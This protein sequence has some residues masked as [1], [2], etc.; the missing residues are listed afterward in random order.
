MQEVEQDLSPKVTN[1]SEQHSDL[2]VLKLIYN[3]PFYIPYR[4]LFE[5]QISCKSD[6]MGNESIFQDIK[7]H[8]FPEI[9]Y[10]VMNVI[11]I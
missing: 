7:Y 11:I 2:L 9:L 10:M 5:A 6:P 8:F 4:S 1:V 3:E